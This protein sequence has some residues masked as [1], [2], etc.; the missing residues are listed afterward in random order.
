MSSGAI[1]T[2]GPPKETAKLAVLSWR[3]QRAWLNWSNSRR[4]A[5]PVQLDGVVPM[6]VWLRFI[7]DVDGMIRYP[8]LAARAAIGLT[9]VYVCMLMVG[10][11]FLSLLVLYILFMLIAALIFF[12]QYPKVIETGQVT[13][14]RHMDAFRQAGCELEFGWHDDTQLGLPD[15]TLW[16]AL[17]SP[18]LSWMETVPIGQGSGSLITVQ[19]PDGRSV[20]LVVPLGLKAGDTFQ[21]YARP[22]KTAPLNTGPPPKSDGAGGTRVAPAAAGT[23]A[24]P[25][26]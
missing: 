14:A 25:M 7:D 10:G 13:G 18:T 15:K 6:T 19:A 3:S 12:L 23:R 26:A 4:A 8:K 16:Y 11:T 5:M 24:M 1:P 9:A 20:D 17:R 21:A 22:P 2:G